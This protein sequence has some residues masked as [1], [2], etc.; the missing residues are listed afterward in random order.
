[1]SHSPRDLAFMDAALGLARRGLGRTAPN[2]TVAAIV[3]GDGHVIGRGVTQP[4]GRPHAERIALD[5]AGAAARGATIYV[6]LEPC[7]QRS[8]SGATSCTDAILAAGISRVVI[9]AADPS[10]FAAGQGAARLRAAGLQVVEGVR[11]VE[12]R[13]LNLGHI[14]RITA[15]R[16][17]V[18]LKMAQ[19]R[20]GSKPYRNC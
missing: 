11:A 12:A 2:P 9:A 1:M 20:D 5:Q 7:A 16:P 15:H 4:G 6:T 10:P 8:V 13:R 18:S 19:S 3:V 14:L 17:S